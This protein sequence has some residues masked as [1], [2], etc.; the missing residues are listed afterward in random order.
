[1]AIARLNSYL[2]E[3]RGWSSEPFTGYSASTS[4]KSLFLIWKSK[5]KCLVWM[6]GLYDKWR[7]KSCCFEYILLVIMLEIFFF[8]ISFC[9]Q[10]LGKTG[11][12]AL[13]SGRPTLPGR[14][15]FI[16]L[17]SRPTCAVDRMGRPAT[18]RI[19]RYSSRQSRS[20]G[21]QSRSAGLA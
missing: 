7:F 8:K 11:R 20:T 13:S 17:C 14:M 18:K 1:M 2:E 19:K 16:L 12:P 6:F 15:F 5:I 4:L 9:W 3:S 10:I 21:T